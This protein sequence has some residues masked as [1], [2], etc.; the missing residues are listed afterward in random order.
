MTRPHPT[1]LGKSLKTACACAVAGA[2][3]A[4]TAA[5]AEAPTTAPAAQTRPTPDQPPAGNGT[6]AK[7]NTAA[8]D[9]PKPQFVTTHGDNLSV[10]QHDLKLAN[11]TIHYTATAGTMKLTEENGKPR[12]EMFFTAYTVTDAKGP[13]NAAKAGEKPTT[14][15]AP[16]ARVASPEASDSP[17]ESDSPS[18]SS[19]DSP[20]PRPITFVFNGGPG[21]A[22][23]W[24]HLGTAGPVR[25]DIGADGTVGAPPY[26]VVPNTDTWLADTD[27]VFIDP[28]GTGYSRPAEGV[29]QKEFSGTRNDLASVAEFIRL[30]L[31][32][33]DRW[34]SP[35]FLAGESYGTTRA[36]ALSNYLADRFGIAASGIILISSVLNF[37]TLSAGTDDDLAYVLHLPSYATIAAYYAHKKGASPDGRSSDDKSPNDESAQ[38]KPLSWTDYATIAK[39]ASTYARTVYAPALMQGAKLPE[40]DRQAIAKKL[41][42]MTGLDA[43]EILRLNLRISPG[44]YRKDLLKTRKQLIG[45]FDARMTGYDPAPESG[46]AAGDPS[47]PPLQAM[48]TAS[49]AQYVRG[50]LGF[51]SDLPYEV[52]TG[53]VQPWDFGVRGQGYLNVA[54]DL[55]SAMLDHP[56]MRVMVA[57]G[58]TD[59]ATPFYATQY[60]FD[61]LDLPPAA[62]ERVHFTYYTGGHM[63][64][65][66]AADRTKLR[67]DIRAF[68]RG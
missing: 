42:Q 68:I 23:V 61:H 47:Y 6:P 36:A 3:L 28:V 24:L 40:A 49:F 5:F 55:R 26:H 33:N 8:G 52:L 30:Y 59:L 27:L 13:P 53:R 2:A 64:Y 12:A 43:D 57:S 15:S 44:V 38:T 19:T 7:A 21:A 48:Y 18:A 37:Q 29:E 25:V 9:K 39:E 45:R 63:M 14:P 66:V 60:T 4:A 58:F 62:R 1:A 65:H 67:D 20:R 16:E 11:Q 22:S 17:S 10:T 32:R 51:K 35:V 56:S 31:T 54:D 34:G 50:D 46:E 41:S